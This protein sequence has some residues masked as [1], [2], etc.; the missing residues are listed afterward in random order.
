MYGD[1]VHICK[2]VEISIE[3]HWKALTQLAG[4]MLDL[5][6]LKVEVECL[7]RILKQDMEKL[8]CGRT[9]EMVKGKYPAYGKKCSRCDGANH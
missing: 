9:H 4:S 3:S 1:C 7:T 5:E 6:H 8:Y 2:A